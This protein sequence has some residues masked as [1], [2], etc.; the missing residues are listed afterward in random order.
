VEVL[1]QHSRLAQCLPA[2][3]VVASEDNQFELPILKG[4]LLVGVP[5][6]LRS[7]FWPLNSKH[8]IR[9]T[10]SKESFMLVCFRP[11]IVR[12]LPLAKSK[13]KMQ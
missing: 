2:A 3:C 1:V 4:V 5:H 9:A 11:T 6:G 8:P 7:G 10:F 13:G 12:T